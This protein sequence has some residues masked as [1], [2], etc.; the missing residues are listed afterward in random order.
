MLL[1]VFPAPPAVVTAFSQ[2]DFAPGFRK[3][4][5][6]EEVTEIRSAE[7]AAFCAK[8][9]AAYFPLGLP[10]P[11][12]RGYKK[13]KSIFDPAADPRR[14]PLY[15]EL[16]A[17]L[18]GA[19]AGR[20]GLAMVLAPLGLGTHI[21]H[22][23]LREAAVEVGR[24]RDLPIAFYE[25]LPY[26]C[27]LTPEAIRSHALAFDAGLEPRDFDLAGVIEAKVDLIRLYASQE[28]PHFVRSVLDHGRRLADPGTGWME[29]LWLDPKA[30]VL[31][32][33]R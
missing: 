17:R 24:E 4:R 12:L 6:R 11:P 33:L 15:P 5:G 14:E 23:M 9:G 18:A 30:K 3:K 7:D 27:D 26:A 13:F 1:G 29:R 10:E 28:L 20:P 22:L 8:I 31:R 19:A 2:S 16:R 21:D 25:D 32:D